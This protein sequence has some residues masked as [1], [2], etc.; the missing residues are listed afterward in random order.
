MIINIKRTLKSKNLKLYILNLK[1]QIEMRN[2]NRYIIDFL[3]FFDRLLLAVGAYIWKCM[4]RCSASLQ[5]F[6]R[7]GGL[8]SMLDII[9]IA[10]Y[11]VKCLYLGALTDIC[12]S[13]FCG[14]CLCTWRGTDKKTGL[15]SLLATI[16]R[17]EE[18][19][20][21]IK[22]RADDSIA[23]TSRESKCRAPY[24]DF[25]SRK[26]YFNIFLEVSILNLR[27]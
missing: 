19:R 21:G 14:P 6:L 25:S 26:I 18:D 5:I 15:I 12:D 3:L 22:R 1:R 7:N 2:R 13:T 11:P 27:F 10:S 8:Y 20:I 24:G 9:E 4:V 23:G 16:W 17:E